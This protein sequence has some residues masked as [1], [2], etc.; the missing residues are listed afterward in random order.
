IMVNM[1]NRGTEVII[2]ENE[3]DKISF[4]PKDI[5]DKIFKDIEFFKDIS[6]N[7]G[8]TEDGFSG[9]IDNILLQHV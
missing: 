4:L 7:I 5:L 6:G 2:D 9:L 8:L 1:N 3:I